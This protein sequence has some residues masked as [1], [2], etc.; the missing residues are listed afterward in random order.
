ME[1]KWFVEAGLLAGHLM[2]WG[3]WKLVGQDGRVAMYG[4]T[5]EQAGRYAMA[6][7]YMAIQEAA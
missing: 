5:E 4:L 3:D 2:Q 6:H 1:N 7:G